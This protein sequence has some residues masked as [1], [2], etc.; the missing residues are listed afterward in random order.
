MKKAALFDIDGT[1]VDSNDLHVTAWD[2]VLREAGFAF[3]RQ[4]LHDQIGKGG[5]SYV[6]A[7]LPGLDPHEQ[8]RIA[9]RHG[10]VFKARFLRDVHPFPHARDL[11]ARAKQDGFIVVLATSA[12]G[13]ELEHYVGLLDAG[14]LIDVR[15]S[16]DD[17][18][19]SKPAPDVFAAALDGA[20]V[21]PERAV[22]IGDT[23][24]DVAGAGKCGVATVALLSG[25]FTAE[26]LQSAGAV[27]LFRDAADLLARYETSPLAKL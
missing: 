16:K 26:S 14:D 7:L 15:T 21:P 12:S 2:E 18:A 5:D 22:A 25:G 23:P 10:E 1:L 19:R 4:A 20:G 9:A 24:Y 13:E 27:A 3:E 6:P 17:V 11:L 8:E